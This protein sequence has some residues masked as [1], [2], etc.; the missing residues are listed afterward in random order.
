MLL[1]IDLGN[2]I[3][4]LIP[5]QK[6]N[7]KDHIKLKRFCTATETINKLKCNPQNEKIFA[8]CI[9]NKGLNMQVTYTTE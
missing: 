4:D 2:G 9:S 5:K 1:D 8:N 7:K 3:L 6:I